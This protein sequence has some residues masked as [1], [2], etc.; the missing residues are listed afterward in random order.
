MRSSEK[1][2]SK[3]KVDMYHVL[4]V[5]ILKGICTDVGK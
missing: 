3:V 2:E 4:K 1:L 5:G